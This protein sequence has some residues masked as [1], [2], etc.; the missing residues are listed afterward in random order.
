MAGPVEVKVADAAPLKHDP[1]QL[2]EE[3]VVALA[4]S[5]S[6]WAC[7]PAGRIPPLAAA[8]DIAVT[9]TAI[10]VVACT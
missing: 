8:I 7:A 5:A 4:C 2:R 1:L 9:A 10:F 6:F 3:I